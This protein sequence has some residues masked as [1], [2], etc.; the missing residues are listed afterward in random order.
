MQLDNRRA[1]ITNFILIVT[2]AMAGFFATAATAGAS[3]RGC[4]PVRATGV[5]AL[6]DPT[7]GVATISVAGVV[8]GTSSARYVPV[9]QEGDVV[10][11]TGDVD[12]TARFNLGTFNTSVTGTLNLATGAFDVSGPV[13][14]TTGLLTGATGRLRF[15]GV[16]DPSGSFT[17]TISGHLCLGHRA[18]TLA[19]LSPG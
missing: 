6:T 8:I 11:L 13:T 18:A 16:L 10:T 4:V 7:T 3:G 9:S 17:E 15:Q 1:L 2:I 5:G 12:F 19:I 14:A